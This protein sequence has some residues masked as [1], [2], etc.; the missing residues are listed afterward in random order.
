[1]KKYTAL[2]LALAV[3]CAGCTGAPAANTDVT[4]T[5]PTEQT[6]QA[7]T[8]PG[9]TQED[10][11][12]VALPATVETLTDAEGKTLFTSTSQ[13]MSL[14]VPDPDV[15]DKII[16]DFLTRQDTLSGAAEDVKAAAAD[17]TGKDPYFYNALF[18][19]KRIDHNVLS[20]SGS[21]VS[22]SGGSHPNYNCIFASYDMV[23]G[24]VLTLGSILTHEDQA[25]AL[26][27]LVIEA[28]G[29]IQQEKGI[30]D[31]YEETIRDR[32]AGN[33]SYDESWYFDSTGLCFSFPPYA[34]S[35]YSSGIVTV[36]VPYEK[37]VGII[38]DAFFPVEHGNATGTVEA[39]LLSD[40]NTDEFSQIAEIVL[41][42]EGTMVLLYTDKSVY[43]V[44]IRV[45]NSYT[46]F[47]T[48]SLTP[49]DAVMVQADLSEQVLILNYR[50]GEETVSRYISLS[51]GVVQLLEDIPE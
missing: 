48:A 9:I 1:M 4:T 6:T 3:L 14:V 25:E 22:W 31:G 50:T 28:I 27:E 10:M 33:V 49:G 12:A 40:A 15:A 44:T 36:T 43:D 51:N 18:E 21:V 16:I 5:A 13:S 46:A 42:E 26:G 34:I 41:D 7:A 24:D 8:E 38:E 30:W 17:N 37:L 23:T 47:A 11:S 29:Q 19:P 2:L 32:F 20:L 35:P 45:D 39:H